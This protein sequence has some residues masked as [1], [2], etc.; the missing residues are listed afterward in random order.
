MSKIIR[1]TRRYNKPQR[2]PCR[3]GSVQLAQA[4]GQGVDDDGV[5]EGSQRR[6]DGVLKTRRDVQEGRDL[7]EHAGVSEQLG[8]AVL[9]GEQLLERV[10][11]RLPARAVGSGLALD[12]EQLVHAGACGVAPG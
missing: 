11:T 6:G 1:R 10:T 5:G 4:S 9:R 2:A 12:A 7:A 8:G 3:A